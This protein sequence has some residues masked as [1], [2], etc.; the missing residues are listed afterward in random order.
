MKLGEV[1]TLDPVGKAG[2]EKDKQRPAVVVCDC[3]Q[4]LIVVPITDADKSKLPTHYRIAAFDSG[5][6]VKAALATTEQARAAAPSRLSPRPGAG[7]LDAAEL[8]GV[9][10]ALRLALGLEPVPTTPAGS[11][12]VKRGEL[13]KMDFGQQ[14]TPEASGEMYALVLSNDTGNFFGRHYLVAPFS[15]SP[16]VASVEV[17]DAKGFVDLGLL[18]VAD[19]VRIVDGAERLQVSEGDLELVE[20]KLREMLS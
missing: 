13:V 14:P 2:D 7:A 19:K 10:Q 15:T 11:P 16:G 5:T 17:P 12:S 18:R 3:G 8:S 20:A 6:Q 1:V 4:T 9:R